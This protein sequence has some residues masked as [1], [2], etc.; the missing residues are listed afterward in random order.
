VA[1]EVSLVGIAAIFAAA[2]AVKAGA[3]SGYIVIALMALA[4]GVRTGRLRAS[5]GP[6]SH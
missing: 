6:N 2:L 5:A 1:I 3:A 4:M